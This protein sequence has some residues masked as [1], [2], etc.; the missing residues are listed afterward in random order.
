LFASQCSGNYGNILAFPGL[1]QT[2]KHT[3][4]I[5]LMVEDDPDD[6]QLIKEALWGSAL[7]LSVI[8]KKNGLEALGYLNSLKHENGPFPCLII[9]DINM[10]VLTGKQLIAILKNEEAFK[11]IPIVVF[12]TSSNSSDKDYCDRFNVPMVT[13]PNAMK[14][15]N[16]TVLQ[17]L[18]HC[19]TGQLKTA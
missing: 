5:I 6:E 17:I 8:H 19:E 12:T 7:S 14:D 3:N 10:P 4:H 2:L 16:S 9:L 11:E 18:E 15:F 1:K 13:K